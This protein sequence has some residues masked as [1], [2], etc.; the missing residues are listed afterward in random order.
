MLAKPDVAIVSLSIVTEGTTSKAAQDEN[1]RKSQALTDFLKKEIKEKGF[2]I[3]SYAESMMDNP[4]FFVS[5][6]IEKIDTVRLKVSDLGFTSSP[7]TD[8][9]YEKAEKL[10]LE[11]CPAETGSHLRLKWIN[12]S[13]NDY[14]WIAMKQIIGSGRYPSVFNVVRVGGGK[15]WRGGDGAG[16]ASG[17][18][19]GDGFLFRFRK[20][21]FPAFIY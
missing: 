3:S 21:F 4:E 18:G 13:L 11:L 14:L 9:I 7:T 20:L 19:L 10:G 6:N 17:W 1:S 8:E 16:P 12:Q 2:K 5:E 15:A